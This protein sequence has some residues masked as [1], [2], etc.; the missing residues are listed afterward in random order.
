MLPWLS[1]TG[2]L[3]HTLAG[4]GRRTSLKQ[5]S[6]LTAL[7]TP[8]ASRQ[9]GLNVLRRQPKRSRV[10]LND[11]SCIRLRPEHPNHVWAYDF[12]TDRTHDG[13]AFRLLTI[14][15][16]FTRECLAAIV[17]APKLTIVCSSMGSCEQHARSPCSPGSCSPH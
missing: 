4:T 12:L 13:R 6:Q 5:A 11:G 3:S 9:E 10:W 15:D 8:N 17:V 16:K 7:V 14:V 2:S 1:A